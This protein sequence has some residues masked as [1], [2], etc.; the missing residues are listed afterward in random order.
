MEEGEGYRTGASE[1]VEAQ[2]EDDEEDRDTVC[3]FIVDH[4]VFQYSIS[5]AQSYHNHFY[6]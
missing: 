4:E 5:G 1:E 2:D 6:C 3:G